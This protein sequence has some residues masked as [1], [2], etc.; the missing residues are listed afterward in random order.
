MRRALLIAALVSLLAPASARAHAELDATAPARGAVVER[1]PSQ[2]ALRFSESVEGSFSAV[3]VYDAA[4]RR[5]DRGT[6]FHPDGSGSR[7]AVRLRGGLA[8]GTYTATYRVLSADGH[9]VSGGSVFSVGRPGPAGE[10]VE[11]LLA[12]ADSGPTTSVAFAL[13]RALQYAAIALG[14]GAVL[15]ALALMPGASWR[16]PMRVAVPAGALSAVLLIW[17]QGAAARGASLWSAAAPATL[18]E[19]LDTRFGLVWAVAAGCWVALGALLA[20]GRR[21]PALSCLPLAFL[22]AA[23]AL[24]G[25]PGAADRAVLLPANVIHVTAMAV[26][27][28]GLC[29]LLF[30]VPRGRRPHDAIARFS[31]LA[32]AS[33][34]ALLITGLVQAYVQ[35]GE[36]RLVAE[37]AYGRAVL[38]KLALL[39]ALVGLGARNRLAG[40]RRATLK[41]EVATIAVVLGVTGALAGYAPARDVSRG[42]FS[43]SAVIAGT[44]VDVTLDPASVGANVA[45]L[46][47]VDPTGGAPVDRAEE[48]RVTA[49]PPGEG[50]GPITERASRSGPGHFTVTGLALPVRGA[51]K[52]AVTVRV[53]AFDESSHEFAVR[54]R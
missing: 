53:S 5:V 1:A 42:P 7:L 25:H 27:L 19:V 29:V 49:T 54:V 3:R 9:V 43:G 10:T 12:G 41:A 47:L 13:V 4:G 2:F 8:A 50:L 23:P 14:V 40:V 11:Q 46:Y 18:G 30:A 35:I 26:W 44:R 6:A 38:I 45:H 28:G 22:I 32:L 15:L 21:G 16:G 36:L 24:S 39:L 31:N 20:A 33:V 37:T 17:L 34:G 48:V 51:W 52:L